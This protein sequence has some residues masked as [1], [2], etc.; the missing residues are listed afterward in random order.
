MV[1]MRAL[2]K[3]TAGPGLEL[4]D[5]PEPDAGPDGPTATSTTTA[6]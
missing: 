5:V 3:T 1:L 6:P 4:L 2:V